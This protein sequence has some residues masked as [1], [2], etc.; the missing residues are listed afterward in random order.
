[1]TKLTFTQG[2]ILAVPEATLQD[3]NGAVRDL[4]GLSVSFRMV[5]WQ[6]PQLVYDAAPIVIVNSQ[7]ATILDALNGLVRYQWT[8][9]DVATAGVFQAWWMVS[10][11]AGTEHFPPDGSFLIKINPAV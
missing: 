3:A 1:M 7:P 9:P 5:V 4:T 10:N 11:G 6:S 8:A 2:D